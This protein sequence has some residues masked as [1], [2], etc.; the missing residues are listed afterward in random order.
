M[1][2]SSMQYNSSYFSVFSPWTFHSE[3]VACE[4]Y[5]CVH[6]HNSHRLNTFCGKCCRVDLVV[7]WKSKG[8][9]KRTANKYL[10]ISQVSCEVTSIDAS[11][12]ASSSSWSLLVH[13]SASLYGN[14]MNCLCESDSR[15]V[16][17]IAHVHVFLY[18]CM[19]D[20]KW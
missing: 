11:L 16:Y 3:A 9:L 15:K 18:V 19:H 5:A 4:S 10:I 8:C 7:H 13:Y 17:C 20:T 2:T 1:R 14:T 12:Q 6:P